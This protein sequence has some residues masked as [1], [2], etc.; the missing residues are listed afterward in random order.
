MD[1][2]LINKAAMIERCLKRIEEEYIGH[3]AEL[4]SNFTRQDSIIL[5]LQR[6]CEAAMHVVRT[7]KLGI[8]QQSRDRFYNDARSN[9][10]G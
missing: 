6:V 5:N 8:P 1:N 10:A 7:H 3:E 9:A 4:E 2:I